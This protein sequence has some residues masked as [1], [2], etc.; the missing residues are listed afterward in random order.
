MAYIEV[1]VSIHNQNSL[2][3]VHLPIILSIQD[4]YK[5][6]IIKKYKKGLQFQTY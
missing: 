3:P 6:Y 5:C 4:P 1:N 2:Q